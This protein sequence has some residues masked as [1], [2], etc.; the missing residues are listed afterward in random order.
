MKIE[1]KTCGKI[2]ISIFLLYLA[3]YYWAGVSSFLGSSVKIN[4]ENL[5]LFSFVTEHLSFI[6]I[7]T[8]IILQ[9]LEFFNPSVVNYNIELLKAL[10]TLS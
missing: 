3:I 9:S 4:A 5:S 2:G 8:Y 6:I 1:W 7:Y 10:N